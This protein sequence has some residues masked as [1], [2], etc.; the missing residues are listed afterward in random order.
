[1]AFAPPI[2][3]AEC[4]ASCTKTFAGGTSVTL[5]PAAAAGS[6]FAGWTGCDS[7]SSN[8]CTVTIAGARNVSAHFATG[9]SQVKPA[10]VAGMANT[11]TLKNDGTVWR[12]GG[13]FNG[14]PVPQQLTELVDAVA[15]S[16]GTEHSVAIT[17]EGRV[18]IWG[19][20][21]RGQLGSGLVGPRSEITGLTDITAI[22]AGHWYTAAVRADG[23]VWSFGDN[24]DGC[25]GDGTTTLRGDLVQA[26]GLTGVKAVAASHATLALK[27]DGTV[28]SWGRNDY[29]QLGDGTTSQ[30]ST[31][32]QISNLWGIVAVASSNSHSLAL[33]AIGT[34]YGWGSGYGLYPQTVTSL[35]NVIAIAAGESSS[36]AVKADGTVW[37]WTGFNTPVQVPGLSGVTAVSASDHVMVMKSDGTIWG[38]G[39]NSSGQLGDGTVTYSST[40]VK[41]TAETSARMPLTISISG[42]GTV[43]TPSAP[44]CTGT[45]TQWLTSGETVGISPSANSGDI[46]VGWSGCNSIV[47]ST[48]VITMSRSQYITATFAPNTPF[49]LTATRIGSGSGSVTSISPDTRINLTDQPSSSAQYTAGSSITLTAIADNGSS[50]SGWRGACSG[51]ASCT[52]QVGGDRE[53]VAVFTNTTTGNPG[54]VQLN[55]QYFALLQ[56]AYSSLIAN[57]SVVIFANALAVTEHL[58]F[59]RDIAVTLKGGYDSN[60]GAN[61]GLTILKGT[62]TITSGSVIM[63]NIVI[64]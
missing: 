20:N 45:C 26:A 38:W 42:N 44:P 40:P 5:S 43:Y 64:Q 16:T 22:A 53:V 3:A 36:I 6:F 33:S 27:T 25:L 41:A 39:N 12:W 21:S 51:T 49:T 54:P 28:W 31:P 55:N 14:S 29:G 15:I 61:S 18:R 13:I 47:D 32:M 59:D 34:V 58:V 23:T 37:E 56:D 9:D 46:F 35:S 19:G 11:L 57:S 17:S 24:N 4:S 7:V 8:S 50:F 48:C 2:S 10:V 52:V 60:F 30:R 62:L 63:E 1:V